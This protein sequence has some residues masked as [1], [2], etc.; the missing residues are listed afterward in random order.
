MQNDFEKFIG[1]Y[2]KATPQTQAL[3]DSGEIGLFIDT[4]LIQAYP[5]KKREMIVLI[6]N[7]VLGSIT[8]EEILTTLLDWSS[9][10]QSLVKDTYNKISS[11]I[12]EKTQ[13]IRALQNMTLGNTDSIQQINTNTAGDETTYTSTQSAILQ[14]SLHNPPV[15]EEATK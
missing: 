11:F 7:K 1:L 4:N 13:D 2:Q 3:I 6:S 9:N 10:D 15:S 14:D 12:I 8:D 5:Q